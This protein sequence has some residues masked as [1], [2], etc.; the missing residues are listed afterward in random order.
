MAIKKRKLS[1][2]VTRYEVAI[3]T[4]SRTLTG[5]D[6][7]SKRVRLEHSK[8]FRTFAEARRYWTEQQ[9]AVD[10]GTFVEPCQMPLGD[11][12]DAWLT[13]PLQLQVKPRTL[14]GYREGVGVI[15]RHPIAAVPLARLTIG[16]L[17]EYYT[18]MALTGPTGKR[19]LSPASIRGLH[20]LIYSALKK[21]VKDR[22]L[23]GNPA[24]GATLPGRRAER[25]P[26]AVEDSDG[27]RFRALSRE[28]A[29]T[30]LATSAQPPAA[31]E[32]MRKNKK[33]WRYTPPGDRNR[34]HALW[35]VLLNGG[36]RPSEALALQW[37][38]VDWPANRVRITKA[39]VGALARGER[40][41][42]E[43]PKRK[44]SRRT[45]ELPPE[46]MD[47]LRWHQ[48]QQ[49]AERLAAGTRYEDHDLIF[50]GPVGRPV[51]HRNVKKRHFHPLLAAAKL[52]R[53]RLYD[54]RHTHCT[55]LLGAGVPVHVVSQ[56][57]G[58]ASAKMTL[59]VYAN[60]LP[61][62]HEDAVARYRAYVETAAR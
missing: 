47:A 26:E 9:R 23:L 51:D 53:V 46:T 31:R 20:G 60:Y 7:S 16:A 28:Q 11:W 54:L 42:F 2:G 43:P 62:Q 44:A 56:R 13:G 22:L 45:V 32:G 18:A 41:R 25:D 59:D 52:P 35:H 37:A 3:T 5:P 21:A 8:T 61:D 30:L 27:P 15:K 29:R 10:Q 55:L 58:H 48:L 40:W 36:L 17:E 57:L 6:G 38:D 14:K 24:V 1:G 12:L 49:E 33:R 39:L 50:A 19:G 34:W 4:G